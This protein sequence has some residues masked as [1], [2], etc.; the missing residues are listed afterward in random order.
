MTGNLELK[1]SYHASMLCDADRDA[2]AQ[3][4]ARD[5][6]ALLCAAIA[7][8]GR[9]SIA[10]SGGSTPKLMF[11]ALAKEAIDWSKVY[12][13][14]VDERCVAL[15][16][17]RS[18]ARLLR[19]NLLDALPRAPI[20]CPLYQPGETVA[21]R[22]ER[23]AV[24]PR[25]FDVVHLGMGADAHTASFFPDAPNIAEMLDP[26]CAE[27]V[28]TTHSKSSREQRITWT[29]SAL[30]SSSQIVVQ[31]CGEEKLRVIDPILQALESGS[32]VEPATRL[33]LPI[34]A[35]LEH[36]RLASP[37]GVPVS[38]YYAQD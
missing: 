26:G 37:E 20:F 17:E 25:P 35:L 30:L 33:E 38:I 36:T 15:H 2:Q 27:L 19:E 34:L 7:E 13:T 14:L 11:A 29:L 6:A 16:H 10:F 1:E 8:Y 4:L 5:I 23:L 31:L 32:A 18:N 12:I 9:A 24:F 3:R 22:G 21:A 28:T